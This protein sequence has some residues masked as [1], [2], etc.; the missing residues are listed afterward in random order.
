MNDDDSNLI[1]QSIVVVVGFIARIGFYSLY[2]LYK[3]RRRR[4][5][6]AGPDP[7]T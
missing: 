4:K 2:E 7:K 5:K 1:K 3:K 6:A